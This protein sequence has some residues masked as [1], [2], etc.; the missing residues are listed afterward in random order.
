MS[1]IV[2][3]LKDDIKKTALQIQELK[4]Q[5]RQPNHISTWQECNE[6]SKLK[7]LATDLCSTRAHMKNRLHMLFKKLQY[8][9]VDVNNIARSKFKLVPWTKDAQAKIAF[10]VLERYQPKTTK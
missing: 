10:K 8:T 9:E 5:I 2:S 6:V 4:K 7:L 3:M 1:P